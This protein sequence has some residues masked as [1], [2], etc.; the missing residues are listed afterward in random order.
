[1]AFL[2][3]E[4]ALAAV[5]IGVGHKSFRRPVGTTDRPHPATMSLLRVPL[6]ICG[7]SLRPLPS[8]DSCRDGASR[9]IPNL[10]YC[11]SPTVPVDPASSH[12]DTLS[13]VGP[14]WQHDQPQPLSTERAADPYQ[15]RSATFG[16]PVSSQRSGRAVFRNAEICAVGQPRQAPTSDRP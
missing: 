4:F 3:P 8:I 2:L 16:A 10:T 6:R 13:P 7:R 9:P 1:M 12:R 5:R 14:H 15:S 11:N